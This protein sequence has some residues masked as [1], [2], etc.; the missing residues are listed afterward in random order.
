MSKL[1]FR[2]KMQAARR[3]SRFKHLTKTNEKRPTTSVYLQR[4]K[5][6][7]RPIK[8]KISN[9][10]NYLTTGSSVTIASSFKRLL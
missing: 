6:V 9:E 4:L 1:S 3:F 10:E 5:E 8:Y 7:C 2:L